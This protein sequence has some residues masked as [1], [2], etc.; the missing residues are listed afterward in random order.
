MPHAGPM[1]VNPLYTV[2]TSPNLS[3]TTPVE[4]QAMPS[5]KSG[6]APGYSLKVGINSAEVS[7]LPP[8][9]FLFIDACHEHPWPALDLLSLS[10]FLKEGAVVALDDIEL[11]FKDEPWARLQDG[12]R[13][14]Y[15]SWRGQKWMPMR[16]GTW[17]SCTMT[18]A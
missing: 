1:A 15:R 4:R 9:D 8:I 5:T 18:R 7:A 16:L 14:L 6:D 2:S 10:R 13:D 12:P 11:I 3:I 17:A